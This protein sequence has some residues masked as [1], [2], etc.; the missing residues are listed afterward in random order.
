MKASWYKISLIYLFCAAT[1][2]T[3]LRSVAYISFPFNYGNLVHT[4][5][6]IAFQGWIYTL[7]FLLLTHFFLDHNQ[8]KKRRYP[9]Q[10]KLTAFILLGILISFALQ[11]YALYSIIFSTLFQLLNYWFIFSFFK[12]TRSQKKAISLRFV[13]TGL[14][15]GVLSTL[16]PFG[17]GA[18]SAKGMGG[19][20]PYNALVYTFLHLQYNGWFLFVVIGLF[21]KYLEV[22]QIDYHLKA[23]QRF[24]G[25]FKLAVLPSIA[26]SFIGMQFEKTILPIAYFSALLLL[27]GIFFFIQSS[28]K[29]I[30]KIVQEKKKWVGLFFAT[31]FIA[32]ILKTIIQSISIFPVFESLAFHN[33][34][35]ILAYLHLSLIGV[36]SFLL[37]ALLIDL[38]WLS[39]S[40]PTKLG[41]FFFFLG[42]ILTE[43]LLTIGGLGLS[44]QYLGLSLG[45]L[46]M[47]IGILFFIVSPNTKA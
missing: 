10:F 25:L 3:L 32:F 33:R 30:Q 45:S 14:W 7:L 41:A 18:L 46:S 1:I 37:L 42:F 40:I 29:A 4:H 38:K 47:V 24:Y 27:L 11:G 28:F 8:I 20:E 23:V 19:T 43:L 21:F 35:I 36:I 6:H 9:L 15:L 17:I 22:N 44:Y 5:S 34:P 39:Y 12:D 2:G 26:L 16:V 31:F 13:N